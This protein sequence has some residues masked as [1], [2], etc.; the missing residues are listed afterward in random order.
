MGEGKS[1]GGLSFE[2]P[3]SSVE[4]FTEFI[5]DPL[6]PVP[7]R[8]RPIRLPYHGGDTTWWRWLVD[9]Q[10]PFSDRP[11]VLTFVSEILPEALTIRGQIAAT[12]FAG[13]TGTDADWIV[14]LIDL[15]PNEVPAQPEL[16]GYQLM[17]SG[18]I[19]RGRYRESVEEASP[20]PAGE[21][22][23]YC[24][25]MPQVNHTFLAGHRIMVQIQSTWFPVYDRNP[26]T[27]VDNI[28][29][30]APDDFQK[31]THRV[32]CTEDAASF[33]ELPVKI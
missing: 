11:D 2:S 10:R 5:S 32:Y 9:D 19:L 6:K 21:V 13:T 33:V 1:G 26:Q 30:A 4:S 24:V 8:V 20:I 29:W 22:L 12:L 23:P 16:G 27:F 17:I 31:A 3:G 7:Y 25:P 28:A 18:D 15:Y 14:K